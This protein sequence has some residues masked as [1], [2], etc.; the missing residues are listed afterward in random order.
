MATG[1]P[2]YQSMGVQYADLPRLSTV[3]QQAAVSGLSQIDQA[4][5][6]MT[7]YFLD[8]ATQEAKEAGMKYA[9]ENPITKEQVDAALGDPKALK[10][11][12]AGRI[13][14]SAYEATQASM[15]AS[16]LQLEGN[17]KIASVSAA[18]KAGGPVDL[19]QIQKD[20]RDM[21]DGY[22]STVM[23]LDPAQAIKLR[24]S[25][26]TTGNALYQEA[27][28][29]A[30][31][32]RNAGIEADLENS[33]KQ[34]RPLVESV[35][36]ISGTIHPDTGKPIN[37]SSV[38]ENIS[39]PFLQSVQVLGK[40]DFLVKFDEMVRESV[41]GALFA[42]ATDPTFAETGGQLADKFQKGDFG[43]L[44]GLYAGLSKEEKDKLFADVENHNNRVFKLK[45]RDEKET[46]RVNKEKAI[47][48]GLEYLN[49]KT[50]AERKIS[51]VNQMVALEYIT[52]PTAKA[53][54]ET[55]S[56]TEGDVQLMVSLLDQAN[57]GTITLDQLAE[58]KNELTDSQYKSVATAIIAKGSNRALNML[59]AE[60]GIVEGQTII[61]DSKR[62]I[63][64]AMRIEYQELIG[65]DN[66][67]TGKP[68]TYAQAAELAIK[69]YKQNKDVQ[70]RLEK[71]REAERRLK[72]LLLK[73]GQDF[74][75]PL[76]ALDLD[77]LGLSDSVKGRAAPWL[78]QFKDNMPRLK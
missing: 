57:R 47:N 41:T 42:R 15:L 72:G 51:L 1:L 68:Y 10:V 74:K 33:I 2:R 28:E 26:A 30:I 59:R 34:L 39:Q 24:A 11:R 3:P 37:I 38:I 7:S 58:R 52:F 69:A 6:Q 5:N 55:K 56:Q 46:Q 31:K 21:I 78:K 18:I 32:I 23:A 4:L 17:R 70:D 76:E 48:L 40:K 16:E 35:V 63:F 27:S 45:E 62:V 60:A 29:A 66:P 8:R 50:S 65:Q 43:N 12:G 64:E 9:A 71:Q 77:K 20:I 53:M 14:Q 22:S 19:E 49:P 36:A 61:G 73:D 44:S 25:L 67:D 75:V 13:F 54:L